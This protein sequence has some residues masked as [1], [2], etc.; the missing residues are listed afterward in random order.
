MGQRAH[1]R[2]CHPKMATEILTIYLSSSIFS[3]S[4]CALTPPYEKPAKYTSL[5]P[6]SITPSSNSN[7]LGQLPMET[8]L[9]E[10]RQGQL[11]EFH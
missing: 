1:K 2:A 9:M 4:N 6:L 10:N 7:K 3:L 8:T 11:L 5:K